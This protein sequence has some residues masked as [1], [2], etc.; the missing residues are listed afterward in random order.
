MTTAVV[1]KEYAV[2]RSNRYLKSSCRVLISRL[3]HRNLF[4]LVTLVTFTGILISLDANQLMA[5]C[6]DYVLVGGVFQNTHHHG[7]IPDIPDH[8]R[9]CHGPGCSNAPIPASGPVTV[10]QHDRTDY[11]VLSQDQLLCDA[12]KSPDGWEQIGIF[13]P[14]APRRSLFR[15][16]R[17]SV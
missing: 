13:L 6:G 14:N 3:S 10:S 17:Y 16:P 11:L 1:L 4:T 15:P 8:H 9:P 5:S 7:E 2:S 12:D